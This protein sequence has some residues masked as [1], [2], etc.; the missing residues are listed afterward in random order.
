MP[1]A[2]PSDEPVE[3]STEP[4]DVFEA[5]L[6]NVTPPEVCEAEDPVFRTSCPLLDLPLSEEDTVT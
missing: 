5:P 6:D 2:T 3:M 4:L 1:P